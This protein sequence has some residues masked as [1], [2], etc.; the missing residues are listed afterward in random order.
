[1]FYNV[2]RLELP[3]NVELWPLEVFYN[4]ITKL[5]I[6][7]VTPTTKYVDIFKINTVQIY[8][9]DG[10]RQIWVFFMNFFNYLFL[11][12]FFTT[13]GNKQMINEQQLFV[14]II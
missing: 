2:G 4:I 3:P 7:Y 6:L 8:I 12:L 10:K 13:S 14:I 9:W 5:A 11:Q 1:M